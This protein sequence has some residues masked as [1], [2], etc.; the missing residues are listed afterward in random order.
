M[1]SLPNKNYFVKKKKITIYS[2]FV[3]T[4]YNI[5]DYIKYICKLDNNNIISMYYYVIKLVINKFNIFFN[6]KSYT[7]LK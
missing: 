7:I 6:V 2:Y 5:F 4:R 3:Y 1:Y